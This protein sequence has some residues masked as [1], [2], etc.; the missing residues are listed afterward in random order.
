MK[1]EEGGVLGTK[2]NVP[3]RNSILLCGILVPACLS[4]DRVLGT[5]Y[6]FVLSPKNATLIPMKKI[7]FFS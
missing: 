4:A 6:K 1:K 7:G 2:Y 3:S 5:S